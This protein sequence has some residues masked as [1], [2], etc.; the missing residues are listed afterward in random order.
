MYNYSVGVEKD[1]KQIDC[2]TVDT[3]KDAVS[4]S[5]KSYID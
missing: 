2:N 1:F 4:V 5:W 3:D